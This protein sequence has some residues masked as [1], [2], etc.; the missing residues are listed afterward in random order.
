MKLSDYFPSILDKN[1]IKF[2]R[3]DWIK[4]EVR[5]RLYSSIDDKIT[6]LM[7]DIKNLSLLFAI[8]E[9]VKNGVKCIKPTFEQCLALGQIEARYD[10]KDYEQPYPSIAVEF[11][12]KY[13]Q[14]VRNEEI[15]V[16]DELIEKMNDP[17]M[18][19]FLDE[20]Q[21]LQLEKGSEQEFWQRRTAAMREGMSIA[22][23]QFPFKNTPDLGISYFDRE[24][25]F[26]LMFLVHRRGM[27]NGSTIYGDVNIEEYL[28]KEYQNTNL[29]KRMERIIFNLNMIMVSEGMEKL[30]YENMKRQRELERQD[31]QDGGDRRKREV[32]Y[33]GL[34]QEIPLFKKKVVKTTGISGILRKPPHPHWRHGHI[35]RAWVG[36]GR[37]DRKIVFI[38]PTFVCS[39]WYRGDMSDTSVD[40]KG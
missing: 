22:Q 25:K 23:Q 16:M 7:P 26:V 5:D 32:Y 37:A 6:E 18:V 12:E 29:L 17:K 1:F 19:E 15:K 38:R 9:L 24:K 36:K 40:Y 8:C 4:W 10:L 34:K 31:R 3:M 20:I 35:R 21:K 11:P 14:Y 39:E 13:I 30:G 28:K 27:G 33:V 2:A